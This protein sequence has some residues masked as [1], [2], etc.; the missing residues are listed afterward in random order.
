MT[1]DK[2][3][4]AAGISRKTL[5]NILNGRT[6]CEVPTIFRLEKTLNTDLWPTGHIS[7]RV[8]QDYSTQWWLNR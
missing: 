3:A 8:R 4:D 7:R 1:Q 6:W 5:Y 2:I